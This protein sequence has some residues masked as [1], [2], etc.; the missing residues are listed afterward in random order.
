MKTILTAVLLVFLSVSSA[1]AETPYM[2]KDTEG[3]IKIDLTKIE[4][5]EYVEVKTDKSSY[6]IYQS[7]KVE[8]LEWETIEHGN[9]RNIYWY[10]GSSITLE[11]KEEMQIK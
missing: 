1:W 4:K 7:G 3:N 11:A 8:K 10:G 9:E 2:E 5:P 6:R